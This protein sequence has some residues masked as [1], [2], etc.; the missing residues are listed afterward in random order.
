MTKEGREEAGIV[1]LPATSAQAFITFNLDE[2]VCG[3]LGD[4]LLSTLSKRKR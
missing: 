3:A 4:N 1:D 2:V